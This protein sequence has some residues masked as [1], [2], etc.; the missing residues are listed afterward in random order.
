M[1]FQLRWPF[2]LQISK[3]EGPV[4]AGSPTA[5]NAV[6]Y[7]GGQLCRCFWLTGSF[8]VTNFTRDFRVRG[9]ASDPWARSCLI[10]ARI[11]LAPKCVGVFRG[12]SLNP[13][14]P[15]DSSHHGQSN[16]EK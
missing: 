1:V 12:I 11:K 7:P 10:V 2:L 4:I 9:D 5:E 16:R 14:K 8:T 15:K 6:G 13:Q 3:A